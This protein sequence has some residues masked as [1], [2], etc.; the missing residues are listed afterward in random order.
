MVFGFPVTL[1]GILRCFWLLCCTAGLGILLAFVGSVLGFRVCGL[2]VIGFLFRFVLLLWF[3]GG[4]VGLCFCVAGY[5]W[6]VWCWAFGISF[7]AVWWLLFRVSSASCL[8]C[9]V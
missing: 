9:V 6:F 2:S 3:S 1:L 7:G 5:S 8:G 4:L